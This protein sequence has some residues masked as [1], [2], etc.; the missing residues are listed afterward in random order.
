MVEGQGEKVGIGQRQ[1]ECP[2]K[3]HLALLILSKISLFYHTGKME[4]SH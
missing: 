3:E 2:L 4:F 1:L